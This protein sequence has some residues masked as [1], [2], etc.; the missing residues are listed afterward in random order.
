MKDILRSLKRKL[1]AYLP[2]NMNVSSPIVQVYLGGEYETRYSLV[3][4]PSLFSPLTAS[5][6]IYDIS[7]YDANGFLVGKRS[8]PIKPFGFFEVRPAEIFGGNLPDLGMFAAKIRSTSFL[9]FSDRHLGRITSHI[10]ALYINKSQSSFAL[11]HPQT[12]IS[13][14]FTVKDQWKSAAL[15]DSNKIRRLVAIQLNPTDL[16]VESN[17]FLFRDGEENKRLSEINGQIPAMGSRKVEWDVRKAGITEGQFSL[18][19]NAL[20]TPNAKPIIFSYFEDG[21][22]TGMHA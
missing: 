18:G 12:P 10:Y 8:I 2:R 1:E 7:L 20:T 5:R 19:A 16:H 4:F 3:N 15:F 11:V 14:K 13:G 6:C 9:D 17:L 22:F 21:T